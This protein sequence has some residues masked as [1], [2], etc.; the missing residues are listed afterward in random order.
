MGRQEVFVPQG[1]QVVSHGSEG[2]AR[3]AVNLPKV[4]SWLRRHEGENL[5]TRGQHESGHGSTSS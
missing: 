3:A 5:I 2:E 4:E 1:V